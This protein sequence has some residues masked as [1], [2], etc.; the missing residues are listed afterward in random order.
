MGEQQ[1]FVAKPDVEGVSPMPR[2]QAGNFRPL[3]PGG[4]MY[5]DQ[6]HLSGPRD[7]LST[8]AVLERA[9]ALIETQGLACGEFSTPVGGVLS[10]GYPLCTAAAICVAAGLPP[11]WFAISR[12]LA[13]PPE[14]A[15]R[16]KAARN[17][18]LALAEHAG[19]PR[20]ERAD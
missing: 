14:L 8:P 19:M 9:A 1:H 12:N 13:C 16:A 10:S 20:F 4:Q 2:R 17:A 15:P 11:N 3:G 6:H 5:T 18:V 7:D